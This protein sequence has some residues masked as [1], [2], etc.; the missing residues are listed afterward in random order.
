MPVYA[1]RQR[2]GASRRCPGRAGEQLA[3][4]DLAAA[5]GACWDKRKKQID[6]GLAGSSRGGSRAA[7]PWKNSLLLLGSASQR[8]WGG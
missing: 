8:W 6:K 2:V 5:T 3:V 7:R 4:G 1:C